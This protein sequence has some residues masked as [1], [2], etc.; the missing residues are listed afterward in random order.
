MPLLSLKSHHIQTCF[1][2][3]VRDHRI[4]GHGGFQR[5][6]P[7]LQEYLENSGIEDCRIFVVS[8]GSYSVPFEVEVNQSIPPIRGVIDAND[9]TLS[10]PLTLEE[11]YYVLA[12][13]PD[14]EPWVDAYIGSDRTVHI[15]VESDLDASK[16][17]LYL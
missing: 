2:V 16:L 4:V 3:R 8:G 9:T 12:A 10:P 11:G 7:A 15:E 1:L 5:L 17:M 6:H 13:Q 14:L